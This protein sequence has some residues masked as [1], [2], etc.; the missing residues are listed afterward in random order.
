MHAQ[1][2][3][4]PKLGSGQRRVVLQ[5][6]ERGKVLLDERG[7]IDGKERHEAHAGDGLVGSHGQR[8]AKVDE[9]GL[10][11]EIVVGLGDLLGGTEQTTTDT[12]M[13]RQSCARIHVYAK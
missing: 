12:K 13:N 11:V 2:G 5:E 6:D 1:I 8:H 10:G 3:K 4:C 9:L 7:Q